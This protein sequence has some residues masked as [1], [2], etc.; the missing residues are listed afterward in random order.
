LAVRSHVGRFVNILSYETRLA[1]KR[2]FQVPRSII[3]FEKDDPMNRILLSTLALGLAGIPLAVPANAQ[4][5]SDILVQ[6]ERNVRM[7]VVEYGD[8]DIANAQDMQRLRDRID[9][10]VRWACPARI[11]GPIKIYPDPRGCRRTAWARA[12]EQ[13]A[14]AIARKAAVKRTASLTLE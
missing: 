11:D 10:A 3:H 7:K 1:L 2:C 12:E 9:V 6:K 4:D 13:L 14:D 8:L 5:A